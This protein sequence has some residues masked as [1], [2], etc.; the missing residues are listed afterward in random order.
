MPKQG[1]WRTLK[2]DQVGEG[3]YGEATSGKTWVDRIETESTREAKED[4]NVPP[5]QPVGKK[6][7]FIA[8]AVPGGTYLFVVHQ[9]KAK[10]FSGLS[11]QKGWLNSPDL[12]KFMKVSESK[13]LFGIFKTEK[14]ILDY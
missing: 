1:H 9:S 11:A 12:K 14:Q 6:G 5:A 7:D 4:K 13:G 3:R 10:E 8:F 2:P